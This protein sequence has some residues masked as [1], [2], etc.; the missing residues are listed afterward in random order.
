METTAVATPL[1]ESQLEQVP[2]MQTDEYIG[3]KTINKNSL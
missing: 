3:N 2:E 1:R